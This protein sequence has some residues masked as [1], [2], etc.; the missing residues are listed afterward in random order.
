VKGPNAIVHQAS[1]C[2]ELGQSDPVVCAAWHDGTWEWEE[3]V[4][5]IRELQIATCILASAKFVGVVD[6]KVQVPT[7]S[8]S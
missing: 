6:K 5:A 3:V 8:R 4:D 2:A 1:I 7:S